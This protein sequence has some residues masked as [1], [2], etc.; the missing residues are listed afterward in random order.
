[1]HGVL[2]EA[3][4][5]TLMEG[6]SDEKVTPLLVTAMAANREGGGTTTPAARERTSGAV[7]EIEDGFHIFNNSLLANGHE[8]HHCGDEIRANSRYVATQDA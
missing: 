5:K 2:S 4:M 8:L 7:E 6:A 3:P 1:M